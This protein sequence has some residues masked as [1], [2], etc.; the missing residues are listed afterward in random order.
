MQDHTH[1]ITKHTDARKKCAYGTHFLSP[2]LAT[3]LFHKIPQVEGNS[4]SSHC[5]GTGLRTGPRVELQQPP[6]R[7]RSPNIL[8]RKRQ[9]GRGISSSKEYTAVTDLVYLES[10]YIFSE[11]K[12]AS[13]PSNHFLQWCA[14]QRPSKSWIGCAI[15]VLHPQRVTDLHTPE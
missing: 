5:S 4:T 14:I 8:L 7:F 2:E 6:R 13:F 11:M 3:D 1:P 12:L 15:L 9:G 10:V